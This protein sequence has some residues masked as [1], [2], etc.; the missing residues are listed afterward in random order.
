MTFIRLFL[1]MLLL[2]AGRSMAQA[3]PAEVP[4]TV[5][6]AAPAV[7]PAEV[8]VVVFNRTVTVFR[9]PYL[10]VPPERRAQ[11]TEAI[12]RELLDRAGQGEVTVQVEP[13]GHVLMVDGELAL[14]LLAADADPL[15]AQTLEQ[16]S[17]A[18][19]DA[20]GQ[21]LAETREGRDTR[22]L[23]YGLGRSLLAT[24]VVAA[25][26]V[27][28]WR[29]RRWAT[30]RLSQRVARSAAGV[31]V[32]GT[33]LLHAERL[34]GIV[35]LGVR[36][37]WWVLALV[38]AYE[39]LSYVLRQFPYTRPWG[40]GLTAYLFGVASRVGRGVLNALP[41][42]VIAGV[43]FLIARGV[44]AMFRPF[45][46]RV[47]ATGN[48]QKGWL[49]AD[50]AGPTRR[51]FSIAVW[52]FAAVMAYP[53]LPGAQSE[54][55]KGMSLL[56]G[57]M[58]TL[59]GSSLFGQAASGLVLMYSRTLRVGEY[60]RI[61][62]HEG[63]VTEM[64]TFITRMRTGL[65][66]ELTLPNTLVL[67]SVSKNYSRAVQGR[68]YVVD[69]VVT[70]GY[71]TPWRQVEA[72]LIEAA[73]RTP[74]VLTDPAPR[75]YQTAL[76]DFYP[77]YRLVCQAI[78]SEPRP[79]AEVL[80]SLHANIQDVFNEN[81]VQIMSPHYLGDPAEPKLVAPGDRYAAPAR[82]GDSERSPG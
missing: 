22:R 39:W 9:A 59:G 55:F 31:R 46:S 24:L 6:S 61:N 17:S 43:I 35:R 52:V 71:D 44:I 2:I 49:D 56:I 41:D 50:T 64:G 65:G 19:R 27:P 69:T 11:R 34:M 60:V 16:A 25:V 8:A 82:S 23:L 67:G 47:A 76:S 40:E 26:A 72:M 18:A 63:T 74:G 73:R 28:A 30:V 10:G 37:L 58:V 5:P 29:V 3:A 62:D 33:E 70:I 68:G 78:P 1:V 81:G 57:L 77:E 4:A 48:Q 53:Y 15:R 32:A 12:L 80:N 54:A 75:V 38:L 13:Q 7:A 20:L 66:E 79:R 45:F 51:L 21:V 36:A 42:L 14:V